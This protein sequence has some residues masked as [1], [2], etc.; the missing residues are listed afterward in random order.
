MTEAIIEFSIK[1][2]T[3]LLPL[4]WIGIFVTVLILL[5]MSLFKRTRASAGKGMYHVSWLLGATTWF[6]GAAV[7]FATWGWLALIIGL[8]LAG[9]GVV[10]I[11]ILAAFI[12]LKSLSLGFSLIVMVIL[13]FATRVGGLALTVNAANEYDDLV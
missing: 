8:L 9:I 7:T 5:P 3:M 2:Y 11:A 13:V 1:A 4:A 12:S 10:P 6:L